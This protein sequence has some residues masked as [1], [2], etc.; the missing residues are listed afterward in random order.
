MDIHRF[1]YM[2]ILKSKQTQNNK[3]K[4]IE[5]INSE[6]GKNSE[7]KY[8]TFLTQE[9]ESEPTKCLTTLKMSTFCRVLSVLQIHP[10]NDF[11]S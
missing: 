5:Q 8:L 4:T 11:C 3:K 6:N 10:V 1:W 7:N 9:I 2:Y